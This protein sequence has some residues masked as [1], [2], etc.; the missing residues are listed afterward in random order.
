MRYKNSLKR[1]ISGKSE[2]RI[3]E[4]MKPEVNFKRLK[5]VRQV[6]RNRIVLDWIGCSRVLQAVQYREAQN[7]REWQGN[8]CQELFKGYKGLHSHRTDFKREENLLDF[9]MYCFFN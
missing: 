3:Y 2:E 4:A 6:K 7:R 5:E 9:R 1:K 8:E